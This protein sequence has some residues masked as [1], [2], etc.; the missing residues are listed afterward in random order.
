[1]AIRF[2]CDDGQRRLT[3]TLSG[4]VTFDAVAS[5]IKGDTPVPLSA[6]ECDIL[7]DLRAADIARATN[8]DAHALAVL[9]AEQ[10]P[11][12]RSGRIAI[13]AEH[14]AALGVAR[15]YAT[16]RAEHGLTVRVFRGLRSAVEWFT[17]R[18]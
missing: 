18:A 12:R 7:I 5:F 4:A 11:R 6:R 8:A 15:M 17:P 9:G 1:M 3:I 2:S 14:E 13:V 16:Y 10:D